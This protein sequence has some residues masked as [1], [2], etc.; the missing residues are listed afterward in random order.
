M[1]HG[2]VGIT[3]LAR[4][5]TCY[6]RTMP[7]AASPTSPQPDMGELRHTL[8]VHDVGAALLAAGVPRSHRQIIRYCETTMLDAVKVPGPT[9]EQWYVSPASVPKV[10]GDLKQWDAQRVRHSAP[11]LDVSSSVAV[12]KTLFTNSDMARQSAPEPAVSSKQ[13]LEEG[14]TTQPVMARYVEQLEKRIEEKNDVIGLLKGQLVAKDGQIGEIS[15]RYRETHALL[16]AMQRMF[17]PLLG[18]SDPY[19]AQP[20][21]QNEQGSAPSH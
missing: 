6:T 15:A 12:E 20:H 18:Q 16:G 13:T 1:A 11:Q 21:E 4:R 17:A 5:R 14:S 9:G 7:D 2:R 3:A 19:K 8:S 10:I